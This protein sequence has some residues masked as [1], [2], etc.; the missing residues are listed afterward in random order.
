[1]DTFRVSLVLQVGEVRVTLWSVTSDQS[2]PESSVGL[3][4]VRVEVR[5]LVSVVFDWNRLGLSR[6]LSHGIIIVDFSCSST[7]RGR[8]SFT[9][10]SYVCTRHSSGTR[11]YSLVLKSDSSVSLISKTSR[12]QVPTHRTVTESP[13]SPDPNESAGELNLAVT[14]GSKFRMDKKISYSN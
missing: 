1:M 6:G 8:I 10:Q 3:G 13:R 14:M 4:G 5:V 11:V 12:L 2:T 9:C 7:S